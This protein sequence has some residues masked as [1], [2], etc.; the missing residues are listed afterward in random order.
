MR[1][2]CLKALK[3]HHVFDAVLK[4]LPGHPP[5]AVE[6]SGE[7]L[8]CPT[9]TSRRNLAVSVISAASINFH[10]QNGSWARS[11]KFVCG[12]RALQ[13]LLDPT[14]S[15]V[16]SRRA[17]FLLRVCLCLVRGASSSGLATRVRRRAISVRHVRTCA[18]S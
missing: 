14:R 8:S 17:A 1:Q 3:S 18:T 16:V 11:L 12:Q 13:V 4:T 15:D 6:A 2:P 7:D 5:A 9:A 10:T